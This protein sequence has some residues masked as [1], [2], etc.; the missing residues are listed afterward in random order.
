[1]RGFRCQGITPDPS[2]EVSL[3]ESSQD[4]A[5]PVICIHVHQRIPAMS[6]LRAVA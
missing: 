2:A 4:K 5:L 6:Q 1:M 3:F